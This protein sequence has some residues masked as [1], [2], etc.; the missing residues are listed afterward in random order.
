M[1]KKMEFT[2]KGKSA[3]LTH[4]PAAMS[5]QQTSGK[6]AKVIPTP[7]EEA[8]AGLYINSD[9][10][11][12]FPSIGIR[13]SIIE[14]SKAF[15]GSWQ[16]GRQTLKGAISHIRIEPEMCEIL[17]AKGKLAK[18]YEIDTRRVVIKGCGAILRSRARFDDWT[19]KFTIIYDAD[20]LPAGSDDELRQFLSQVINDAG[21][22]IGIGDYRP[23]RTGWF[24]RFE[25]VSK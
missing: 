10:K 23:Q 6:S 3:I 14:A 16:K 13:N 1:E 9:G 4:N 21:N 15:R 24:G 20:L 2:I 8:Y 17:D 19:M 18:Q 22:R 25:V 7:Q 11:Y 12:C 5:G